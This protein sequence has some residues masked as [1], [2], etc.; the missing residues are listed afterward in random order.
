MHV[1]FEIYFKRSAKFSAVLGSAFLLV[2]LVLSAFHLPAEAAENSRQNPVSGDQASFQ[3]CTPPDDWGQTVRLAPPPRNL[4]TDWTFEVT[5]LEMGVVLTLFYY[6]DYDKQGCPLDCAGGDCQVDETG[7]FD[8]PLGNFTVADGLL[9]AHGGSEKLEG[10]LPQGSYR[11]VF[12]TTGLGSINVGLRVR[13]SSLPTDTPPP[14][15]TPTATVPTETPL[16]T[17]TP[18][19]TEPAETLTAT[20]TTS[21]T[22]APPKDTPTPTITGTILPT[23]LPP[24]PTDTPEEPGPSPTLTSIPP[25]NPT[26]TPPP[27]LEPP[28]PPANT[29]PGPVL[30]PVTGVDLSG[31]GSGGALYGRLLLHTGI[32]LLGL[33]LVFQGIAARFSRSR[34]SG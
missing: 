13:T 15:F 4:A 29:T 23:V 8:T 20:P 33:G 10:S 32:G 7:R 24:D 14:T 21:V 11:V 34:K 5:D 31:G 16:P 12:T 18:T 17:D 22:P 1:Q 2:G 28:T 27:T 25:S 19:A 30:I 6:Q 9:G 26:R 3:A